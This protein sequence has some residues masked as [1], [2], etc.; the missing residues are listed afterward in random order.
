MLTSQ[1]P[2]GPV[3]LH[4]AEMRLRVLPMQPKDVE[5]CVEVDD[6]PPEQRRHYVELLERLRRV[7]PLSGL[8]VH[9]L[10]RHRVKTMK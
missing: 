9:Q 2:T 8:Q 7:L 1:V 5:S 4:K 10:A 3:H 6:S